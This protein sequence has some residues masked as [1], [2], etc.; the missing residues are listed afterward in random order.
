MFQNLFKNRTHLVGFIAFLVIIPILLLLIVFNFIKYEQDVNIKNMNIAVVNKD[1][2]AKFKG[3]TVNVGKEVQQTLAKDKQVKWQF[4]DAKTAKKN[5]ANGTYAMQITLPKDFSKNVTT[6]LDKNP[7]ISS[8]NVATSQKNNYLAGMITSQVTEQ[9]KG[10]VIKSIQIAYDEAALSALGQLGDGVQQASDGVQKLDDASGQLNDGSKQI[11][12]NM[13]VLKNG[14]QQL[15]DGAAPL[16]SGVQ[17]L[18]DGAHQLDSGIDQL[19]S[20]S[21]LLNSKLADASKQIDSQL[22]SNAADL[23]RLQ[24]GLT[25]LN[26]G[27]QEMN[28]QINAPENDNSAIITSDMTTLGGHIQTTGDLLQDTGNKLLDVKA[29]VYDASNPDSVV[30]Q[31][32]AMHEYMINDP[33]FKEFLKSHMLFGLKINA[34]STKVTQQLTTTGNDDMLPVNDN[35]TAMGQELTASGDLLK[36]DITKQLTFTQDNMAKLKAGI[37]QMAATDQAPLALNG[38]KQAIDTL[39]AGLNEVNAGLKQQGSTTDTMGGIQATSMIHDGLVQ[40]QAG[41]K[42]TKNKQG[43]VSGL[44][45]LNNSA[46]TLVSGITQLND[47]AGKLADGSD[48]LTSGLGQA[49]DGISLLNVKLKDGSKQVSGLSTG[50]ANVN[51]F[52]TPVTDQTLSVQKSSGN[53]INTFAPL[54]LTLVFFV[55]AMLTQISLFRYTNGLSESGLKQKVLVVSGV[56]IAQSILIDIFAKIFGLNIA[57]LFNFVVISLLTS[58]AFT[59]ACL[60]LDKLFGTMG[61]LFALTLLF[62]QIIITGGLFPNE[63]LSAFYRTLAIFLP[64]T[65]SISGLEQAVNGNGT[66]MI[67]NSII[68]ILFCAVFFIALFGKEIMA[69]FNKSDAVKA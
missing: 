32:T 2:P 33:D 51:H 45:T 55:G 43:L 64:G 69:K 23:S 53:L 15:A 68:L 56:I 58:A 42:G 21:G 24:A 3:K 41:I 9:L 47:G 30:S 39:T 26:E 52:V 40:V 12:D 19:A 4:V 18:T 29:R 27:I 50:K 1:V 11:S 28:S 8:L 44:T 59:L 49:G 38:A 65:Y 16:Q 61:L 25:A 60:A 13:H 57:Q 20:G 34:Y 10:K 46:P 14:T 6:A 62:L 7:K 17:Q 66:Q 48:Q 67:I 22:N 35:L 36:G 63:M 5:L 37:N 31:L 54:V